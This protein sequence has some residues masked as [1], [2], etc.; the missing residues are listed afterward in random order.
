M[1]AEGANRPAVDLDVSPG[2]RVHREGV[3]IG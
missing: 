1:V 2:Q 3:A